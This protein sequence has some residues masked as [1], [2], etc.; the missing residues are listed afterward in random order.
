MEE[1]T[2]LIEYVTTNMRMLLFED[3]W[4]RNIHKITK[5]WIWREKDGKFE[6]FA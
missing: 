5:V 4:K 1:E 6:T 2:S 3:D